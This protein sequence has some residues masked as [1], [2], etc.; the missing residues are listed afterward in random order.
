MVV[1]VALL[2]YKMK[3]MDGRAGE[4]IWRGRISFAF[5][6]SS[7]HLRE[8]HFVC[9]DATVQTVTSTCFAYRYAHTLLVMDCYVCVPRPLARGRALSC[10]LP[11]SFQSTGTEC[12]WC[13]RPSL[14]EDPTEIIDWRCYRYAA[15][16]RSFRCCTTC[17]STMTFCFGTWQFARHLR[18]S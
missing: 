5:L 18:G 12:W 11:A 10:D 8:T 3:S 9:H 14:D 1:L 2:P 6:Y 13:A 16:S 4:T 7:H 17:S 15:A